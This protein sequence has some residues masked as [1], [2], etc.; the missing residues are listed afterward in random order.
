MKVM[1]RH[2][3]TALL[4]IFFL[5]SLYYA[6]KAYTGL[7]TFFLAKEEAIADRVD[8]KV[9]EGSWGRY[10][11]EGS[12]RFKA[13]S[14]EFSGQTVLR[15]PVFLNKQSAEVW[16]EKLRKIPQAVF[17]DRSSPDRSTLQRKIPMKEIFSASLL[18][19]AIAYLVLLRKKAVA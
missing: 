5:I 6:G 13:D 10:Y 8:W 15:E 11:L 16:I 14:K 2:G 12:Y 19:I 7:S 17:Y 4:V 1:V 9:W 3:A 18:L